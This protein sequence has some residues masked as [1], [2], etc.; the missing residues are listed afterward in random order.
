[1]EI[2]ILDGK[3]RP[4]ALYFRDEVL[5]VQVAFDSDQHRGASTVPDVHASTPISKQAV[6]FA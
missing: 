2:V 6:H 4:N 3:V 5:L 1:M